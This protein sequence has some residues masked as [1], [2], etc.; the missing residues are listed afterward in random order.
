MTTGPQLHRQDPEP[1]DLEALDV[2]AVV[3]GT[4]CLMIAA[5]LVWICC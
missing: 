4:A 1:D 2:L 3:C 5:A